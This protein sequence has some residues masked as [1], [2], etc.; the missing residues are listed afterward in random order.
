MTN[1]SFLSTAKSKKFDRR[2]ALKHGSALGLGAAAMATLGSSASAVS[3]AQSGE[4]TSGGTLNVGLIGEPPT[5]DI[6]QSGATIVS[7]VMWN[8]Y[9][10]LFTFDEE[11]APTPM[12]AESHEVSDDGLVHT[13]KLRQGVPFHNG[14][15]LKA[16]DVIASVQRWGEIHGLGGDLLE[17]TDEIVPVDDYTVEFRLNQPFGAFLPAISQN[18]GGLGIYP[19]S[20]IDAAGDEQ[21]TEFIGTGPY[22]FVERQADRF[23]RLERFDDYAALP[24]EP[25]G[26][27]GHK[28][29]YLDE[30][31]FNPVPDEAARIAGL[32]AGDYHYLESITPDQSEGLEGNTDVVIEKM[33]PSSWGTFLFNWKSPLMGNQKLRQAVQAALNH[34][35]IMQASQGE[36]FYRLDPGVMFQETAWYTTT[37]E[38]L[39]NRNDPETAKRLMEEAGYDGTPLRWQTT[40]EYQYMYN[41]S[42]VAQQQLEEVGFVIDLQV[43]DW[44]TVADNMRKPDIWDIIPTGISFKPDPVMVSVI[45]LCTFTGWWC[46]DTGTGLLEDL[47]RESDFEIRY[48]IWEQLQQAFYD[49]AAL[50]KVGDI[51][52]INVRSSQ[53]KGYVPQT[54]IGPILWNMWLEQ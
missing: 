51:L 12:L 17:S 14:E 43:Y 4:G 53:V 15:E 2:E 48:G 1:R 27:G 31:V 5:L 24:G 11:F 44:A 42:V 13:V 38:D 6:H 33:P 21:V 16:P 20:V 49:E 8:V 50:I 41:M 39:Y 3:L 23:I 29:Q 28:Y 30:I 46:S 37:G 52:G 9:E 35:P 7:F 10:P 18:V 47:L 19:K 34:E 25:V 22:R 40:Q 26:Y 54:Q 32:Q 36:G 45:Q